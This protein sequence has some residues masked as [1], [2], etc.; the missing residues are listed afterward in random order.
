M[1]KTIESYLRAN[2]PS[3]V[4]ADNK[5]FVGGNG[6]CTSG[7]DFLPGYRTDD[8]V[9]A[10]S[11]YEPYLGEASDQVFAA[12]NINE[13]GGS[14]EDVVL[15]TGICPFPMDYNASLNPEEGPGSSSWYEAGTGDE[16]HQKLDDMD[17]GLYPNATKVVGRNKAL[18]HSETHLTILSRQLEDAD[19]E[20]I[21]YAGNLDLLDGRFGKVKKLADLGQGQADYEA[22]SQ[23]D[24]EAKPTSTLTVGYRGALNWKEGAGM[25][26]YWRQ[27]FG[28]V[29][30]VYNPHED[31]QVCGFIGVP[32]EDCTPEDLGVLRALN[33][34][35][36]S[37]L[38]KNS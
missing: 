29:H 18:T 34:Q 36:P 1:S 9:T 30:A 14:A 19:A 7:A 17:T 10:Q 2:T 11:V 15:V 5:F 25:W 38:S 16:S 3:G 26:S 31:L 12:R 8:I 13:L 21:V 28:E 23:G 27:R 33:T 37:R 22:I 4:L 35:E 32:A 6:N 24:A 20:P